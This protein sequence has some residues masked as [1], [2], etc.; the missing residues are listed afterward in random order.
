MTKGHKMNMFIFG[1]LVDRRLRRGRAR[2]RP[3]RVLLISM[4]IMF[5]SFAWIYLRIKGESH[6]RA[7]LSTPNPRL[8]ERPRRV[9]PGGRLSV[10]QAGAVHELAGPTCPSAAMTA[11]ISPPRTRRASRVGVFPRVQQRTP[12]RSRF[13][14]ASSSPTTTPTSCAPSSRT[15]ERAGHDVVRS[16]PTARAPASTSRKLDPRDVDVVV[17][18][19][20][21][22]G[23]RRPRGDAR[24]AQ[25]RPRPAR[26]CS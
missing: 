22:P 19:I 13:G 23:C 8:A 14:V 26:C 21:M 9:R 16:S 12:R 3:R 6:S 5:I 1:L 10:L 15:L 17:T 24:R 25:A 18:D 4:P 7:H 2:L 11:L 20:T